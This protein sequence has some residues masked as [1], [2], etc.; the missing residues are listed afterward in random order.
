MVTI[1]VKKI[2][3]VIINIFTYILLAIL[4]LIIYG[5]AV[6]TFGN[7]MYPNFFG[8]TVLQVE[9]GSMEPTISTSDV[10]LVRLD[11]S[12][13]Q[14]DDIISYVSENSIITHRVIYVDGDKYTCKGDANNTIDSTITKSM[15]IGEVVK[16]YPKLGIW[17][18]VF[19]EPQII[20]VLFVTL[21]LFDIALSKKK[22]NIKKIDDKKDEEE[23]II[24]K[25]ELPTE[26]IQINKEELLEF[27]KTIDLSEINKMLSN[28]DDYKLTTKEVNELKRDIKDI[29]EEKKTIED[30]E[31]KQIEFINYTMRLDLSEIQNRLKDRVK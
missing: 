26:P 20:I 25:V 12:N 31:D 13:V 28:N 24:K 7:N 6:M 8:Y 18:K 17:K 21:V 29:N 16:I 30:L 4:V 22:D 3:K 2:V 27:T 15:I 11:N 9:S 23:I 10:V 14:K 19:S 5:K 1:D